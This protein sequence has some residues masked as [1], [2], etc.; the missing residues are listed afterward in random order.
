MKN[1]LSQ[2]IDF[3]NKIIHFNKIPHE[4]EQE[5]VQSFFSNVSSGIFVDVGAND[6]FIESQSYHLEK[7]GWHGL[8]IEPLPNMCELLRQNRTGVV[9]PYACSSKE[10]HK[11]ILPLI[12][13][14]VC[15]TLESKLIHTNKVKQEVIYI[16]TRTLD[17]ILEENNIKEN[18]DLISI[19]VEGHEIEVIKSLDLIKYFKKF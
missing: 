3:K 7:L 4:L 13:F 11:K 12:S 2:Y 16:E 18:F 17:S 19:D 9:V 15:S 8:L 10:N 5:C 6:P 14:G 1:S